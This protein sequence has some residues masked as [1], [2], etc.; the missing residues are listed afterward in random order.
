MVG[1]HHKISRNQTGKALS[2]EPYQV[3]T[4]RPSTS[5]LLLRFPTQYFPWHTV[6]RD[7]QHMDI[8][9]EDTADLGNQDKRVQQLD[10]LCASHEM[11]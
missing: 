2:L 11:V 10:S 1:S 6:L 5:P 9:W 8:S 3:E 4:W 7:V